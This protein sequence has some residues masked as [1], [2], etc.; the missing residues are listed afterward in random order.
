MICYACKTELIPLEGRPNLFFL[1][2]EEV[3]PLQLKE[4]CVCGREFQ[5]HDKEIGMTIIE[6]PQLRA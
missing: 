3:E 2:D 4:C 1:K 6:M 5:I